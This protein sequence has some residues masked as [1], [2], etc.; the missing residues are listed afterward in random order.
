MGYIDDKSDAFRYD[1][2][3]EKALRSVVQQAL[4]EVV[5]KGLLAEH[6]FYITFITNE[7]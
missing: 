3:V 5:E 2:M 6:H 7:I 1:K 4:E